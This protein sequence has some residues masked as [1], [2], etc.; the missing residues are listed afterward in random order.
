MTIYENGYV[1]DHSTSRTQMMTISN[2]EKNN[3]TLMDKD[4]KDDTNPYV[5]E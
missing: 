3:I 5:E 4:G 1:I 2:D